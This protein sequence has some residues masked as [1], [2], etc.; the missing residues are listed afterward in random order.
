MWGEAEAHLV[1]DAPDTHERSSPPVVGFS[2]CVEQPCVCVPPSVAHSCCILVSTCTDS[3][4]TGWRQLDMQL[5]P[6]LHRGT[7]AGVLQQTLGN[8]FSSACLCGV[9]DVIDMLVQHTGYGL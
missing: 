5:L 8:S 6:T 2:T 9:I 1:T 7:S 4:H 3:F